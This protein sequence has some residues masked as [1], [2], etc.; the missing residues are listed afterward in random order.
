[1]EYVQ[2]GGSGLRVSRIA[3]G[4]MT[5]GGPEAGTHQWSLSEEE[6]RGHI[7]RALELGI[8][9]FDSANYYSAGM[10]EN[11]LGRALADFASRDE[12]VVATKCFF[13]WRNAPNTGG[14]SRKAIFQAVDDSL[15]RLGT[16]YIDLYQTHRW[17]S[18]TPIEETME[19]LHD[20]VKSGKVRYIG[21]SSMFAWQFLKAQHVAECNGWTRFVSMQNH[22]NLLYR[23][24][25]REMLPMCAEESV[26]VIPWSPLARGLLARKSNTPTARSETDPTGR[27]LYETMAESDAKIVDAVRAVAEARR[28]TCAQVALAW[29]RSKPAVTA[30]ILGASKVAQIEKAVA[31][32][33]LT[34]SE[35][36]IESLETHYVP[37]PVSGMGTLPEAKHNL[38]VA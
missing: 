34:L 25:E 22:L 37:H 9:F 26:G 31:S 36:E 20:V 5:Y 12:I 29:F 8:N 18:G 27:A 13:H 24:E 35:Q 33:S 38:T 7:R 11:I 30:P 21:A 10:S 14:L 4:C 3:L 1:M 2:L 6:S 17:D 15:G 23:E 16:D 28:S 19:A 32:L